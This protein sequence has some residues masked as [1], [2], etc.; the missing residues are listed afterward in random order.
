MIRRPPRSTLFPYTTLFRSDRLH[1]AEIVTEPRVLR[2]LSR[3]LIPDERRRRANGAPE[4]RERAVDA[5]ERS[6]DGGKGHADVLDPAHV[7]D[8]GVEREQPLGNGELLGH[9][10]RLQPEQRLRR[11]LPK[12]DVARQ[13][14]LPLVVFVVGEI[15]ALDVQVERLAREQ[16]LP[17]RIPVV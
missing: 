9:A 2:S 16:T 17:S 5:R 4:E 6:R 14:V 8:G 1:G 15:H 10:G 11:E 12:R 3:V 13:L 7:Q